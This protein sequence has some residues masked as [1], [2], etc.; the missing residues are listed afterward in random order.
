MATPREVK[1]GVFVLIGL[2]AM[3]IVVFLIG[4]VRSLFSRKHDY[5][6]VVDSVEGLK[7]GG[8][9]RMGGIDVGSV[10]TVGYSFAYFSAN[11]AGPKNKKS[12]K[13]TMANAR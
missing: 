8:M 3:G 6:V 13:Q 11:R 7:R 10:T 1:V 5:R 4:D 2:I 12:R 9:V